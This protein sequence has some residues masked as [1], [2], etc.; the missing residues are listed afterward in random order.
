MRVY[1]TEKKYHPNTLVN[2]NFQLRFETFQLKSCQI[3]LPHTGNNFDGPKKM[4]AEKE[5]TN[6]VEVFF[7]FS[8]EISSNDR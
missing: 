3:D 4:L 1:Y 5:I 6:K 2:T 7:F 8:R